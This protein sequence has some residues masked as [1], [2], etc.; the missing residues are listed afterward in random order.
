MMLFPNAK[1]NIGLNILNKRNDGFH[2]LETLMVPIPLK[3]ELTFNVSETET[4]FTS[5]GLLIDGNPDDN[6]VMKA[7]QLIKEDFIIPN[8]N[9]HLKKVIPFGA[10]MGGGSADASF[11]LK[12]LND[13]FKLNITDRNLEIYAEQLGSDCPFFIKNESAISSGRGEILEAF[14]I[15]LKGYHL[16]IVIP[17]LSIGTKEAYS[18][19]TPKIPEL[20]L[21]HELTQPISDWKYKVKNDFEDSV[22]PQFPEVQ[23]VKETLYNLGA[24]YAALSG[25]GAA[26]FALSENALVTEES[27]PEEYF[28]FKAIL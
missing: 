27:F 24:D 23:N 2:E 17:N 4:T 28:Q 7:Y 11:M 26:V 5:S 16:N 1:I 12:G 8:L 18:K 6:L 9:I 14:P 10:G 22:F 20:K 3:D 15:E 21:R 13:F 19:V 25:S